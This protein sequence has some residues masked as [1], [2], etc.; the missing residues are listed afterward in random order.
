MANHIPAGI[1]ALI[2]C[3]S[4][5]LAAD[6]G[7]A[8]ADGSEWPLIGGNAETW[9]YSPLDQI[10]KGNVKS[11]GLAW[12]ADMPTKDG[13]VGNPLVKDGVVFQSGP[14]GRIYANDVRT[15]K[16]L[17]Q[18]SPDIEFSDKLS[19]TAFYSLRINR[20]L[21]ILDDKVFVASGDCRLFAVDRKTGKELWRA[22][23]C[24]S[25]KQMGIT[26]APRVGGGKVFIGN[27]CI[28]S[29]TERGYVDAFDASTGRRLWRFY[30][31]PGDPSKPFE[32]KA[33]EMASKTWGT[34]YWQKTHGCVSPYD[35]MTFDPKLNLLYIGTGSPAPFNPLDRAR[36]AGDELF[37]DSIVAVN[38][39]TGEYVWHY[40][41]VQHDGW[42]LD[43]TWQ[44]TIAELPVKGV[45]RRVLM[46]IP[47]NG[48]F[49][50]LDAATGKFLSA[51]K[52]T[53]INWASHVDPKTGRPV[54]IP[55]ARYWE[56]P[57]RDTVTEPGINGAHQWHA[58]SFNPITG[59]MYFHVTHS[60][61][62]MRPSK[63]AITGG[64]APDL[65]FK[66]SPDSRWRPYGELVAW[67]PLTQSARWRVERKLPIPGGVLS[68][69]GNLVFQGTGEG[70]LEAYDAVTGQLLWSFN[71]HASMAAAPSTVEIDGQQL[72]IVSSGNSSSSG[73]GQLLARM[74]STLESR[75]PPRLLAFKLGG[76]ASIPPTV[77][78]PF[79]KPPLPRPDAKLAAEGAEYFDAELCT[80]CHGLGVEN[81]RS[82]IPDLRLASAQTHAQFPAIVLGGARRDKG[83]PSFPHITAQELKA[84]QAH[85]LEAAWD[86]YEAQEA[87]KAE[88]K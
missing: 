1:L 45:K 13:L 68:T 60:P 39:S 7:M 24:D 67:D 8:K 5:A 29:G 76:T 79:P 38:A 47:K 18:F 78:Q 20:G 36:D 21:S 16:A 22:V 75:A 3:T 44:I 65:Y 88:R 9:H 49:Y 59:L 40:Q 19:L 81:A 87:A 48:F 84:L 2:T 73:V 86:A 85:I 31:M 37:A 32:S 53:S 10:N 17:W 66:R 27:N 33:M 46:T 77:V 74:A 6:H 58:N 51:G 57:E 30:T 63:K 43:A 72:L 82:S 56:H 50:V 69:A 55:D 80:A 25:T 12:M 34:G 11:L 54:T 70:M 42:D 62:I 83:M 71:T 64:S 61:A 28:D 26:G 4:P 35:A 15:G 23:S 41:T 14:F 52:Y